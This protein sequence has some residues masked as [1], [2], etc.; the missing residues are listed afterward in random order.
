MGNEFQL[1]LPAMSMDTAMFQCMPATY[2]VGWG[3]DMMSGSI[4]GMM[5]IQWNYSL[6]DSIVRPG[7]W[8]VPYPGSGVTQYPW[9]SGFDN[10]LNPGLALVQRK[11]DTLNGGNATGFSLMDIAGSDDNNW[12]NQYN[13]FYLRTPG[14]NDGSSN[15]SRTKDKDG[16]SVR[17]KK[18]QKKY[19]KLLGFMKQLNAYVQSESTGGSRAFTLEQRDQ[20]EE[21]VKGSSEKTYEKKYKEL[22]EF[23]NSLNK[24][25]IKTFITKNSDQWEVGGG[26]VLER[27]EASGY[28]NTSGGVDKIIG[29]FHKKLEDLNENDFN[30]IQ[31]MPNPIE[32]S[33][34]ES[35]VGEYKVLDIIS[36][37]NSKYPNEN[38]I[39]KLFEAY[40]R[41]NDEEKQKAVRNEFKY[42]IDALC[43]KAKDTAKSLGDDETTRLIEETADKLDKAYKEFSDQNEIKEL[44]NNLYVMTRIASIKSLESDLKAHYGDFDKDLFKTDSFLMDDTKADIKKE[45]LEECYTSNIKKVKA[46]SVKN[47]GNVNKNVD[48]WSVAN[49]VK[50]LTENDVLIPTEETIEL[51]E[52]W[53][54]D[55]LTD[56]DKEEKEYRQ[57]VYEESVETGERN[58]KR[59]FIINEDGN[60]AEVKYNET[61]KKWEIVEGQEDIKPTEISNAIYEAKNKKPATNSETEKP[62]EKEEKEEPAKTSTTQSKPWNALDIHKNIKGQTE[63]YIYKKVDDTLKGLNENNIMDFLALYYEQ[64]GFIPKYRLW[65]AGNEGILEQMDDEHDDDEKGKSAITMKNKKKMVNAMLKKAEKMG[66]KDTD[67]Y[68]KIEYIMKQY[69]SDEQDFN[70]NK[71][72]NG[73][74]WQRFGETF[75]SCT[76]AGLGIGAC[77][78]GIGAIPGVIGGAVVGLI[79]GLCVAWGDRRTDNEAIDVNMKI[80]YDEIRAKQAEIEAKKQAEKPEEEKA[81]VAK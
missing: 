5:N 77:V 8:Q 69:K 2:N 32:A 21:L 56:A 46:K 81:T 19:N 4:Q 28:E 59:K 11:W 1:N 13:P 6:M 37:Y 34:A 74:W 65:I 71:G 48:N 63:D 33:N 55:D 35:E 38:L 9:M 73:G 26:K 39:D 22:Q 27:L 23:Y 10:Y 52:E 18:F 15:S 14:N 44:F 75:G 70:Y 16:T 68:M 78:G 67:A 47:N 51:G 29:D 53:N 62:E 58:Y 50:E 36:S 42:I 45:G 40:D 54:S 43:I 79:S 31:T 76:V 7:F 60:F 72:K 12:M 25:D 49:K 17:E 61:E 57:I 80:L 64:S 24:D 66:L 30:L 41:V 3:W 20:L